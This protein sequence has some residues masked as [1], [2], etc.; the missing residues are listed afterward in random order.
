M[1]STKVVFGYFV[2]P[3][4]FLF[5]STPFVVTCLNASSTL[6]IEEERVALLKI[7]LKLD[8]KKSHICL[9]TTT[10]I[11]A[12]S[13]L[14]GKINPSLTDL[15]HLSY[16]NFEGIPIPNFI[17]SLNMLRY[18]DLSNANFSGM[19]PPHLGNLSNL[20]YLDISHQFTKIWVR[21][22]S[23]LSALS[24]LQY[25]HMDFV[26]ITSTPL[27]LFKA[28]NTIS[29]LLELHLSSCNLGSLPPH[30]PFSNITSLSVLDLSG[31][32]FNSSIPYWLFNIST[33][34]KLNLYLSSL[35]GPLPAMP[36]RWNLCKLQNLD[37]SN[38]YYL[39]GDITEMIE[40]LS[41]SN[42]SLEWLYLSDNQLTGRLPHSL[43]KFNSLFY[44]DLSNNSLSGPIPA[45]IGNLS[46]LDSLNLEGNMMNGTIPE[47]IGQL[48]QLSSL[49][50]LQNYWEGIMT[51][52]HFHN[53]T[54]LFS[55]SVSSKKKSFALKMAND[56][57]PPFKYLYHVEI[58]DCQVG[59]TF[60]NWLI[61][62]QMSLQEI[63]LENVGISE[64]IPHWLYNISSQIWHLDL[65]HNNISGYLP[66]EMNFSSSK[67]PTVDF[68]FNQLKGPPLSHFYWRSDVTFVGLGSLK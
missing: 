3:L 28:V 42:Q 50:L 10:N 47:S 15:K 36:G 29:S 68:S 30:F 64:E 38:N 55:F 62:I 27:E 53:L 65:S 33:L 46:N 52:I 49:N 51:N 2:I 16:N 26:N 54:N 24:S 18:L 48:S 6:C 35:R 12:W 40:A 43:D 67:F 11:F 22:I 41:C 39:T 34:T 4:L 32:H 1:R 14:S 23:W 7:V 20:Y 57:V 60:P 66:K 45:S 25:L 9:T 59:S 61:T 31:N 5:V 58:H 13:P 17:G 56:R 63:I 21:D 44:L 37:L 8:L 19:I